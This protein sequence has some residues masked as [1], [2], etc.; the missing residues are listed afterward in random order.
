MSRRFRRPLVAL[1]LLATVLVCGG[2]QA[3]AWY[4]IK[5]GTTST[6]WVSHAFSST[7]RFL[8]GWNDG[9]DEATTSGWR[10][11]GWW[12]IAPGGTSTIQS[13]GFGN[14]YHQ[15]Y[16]HDSVGHVWG[17]G[18]GWFGTPNPAF[19]RCEG[20]FTQSN[21]IPYYTYLPT[22]TSWC[23]GGSCVGDWTSTLVL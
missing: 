14:A 19:S 17:G 3:H 8:C 16:A 23:C 1:A 5:N 4:K 9:C 2:G 18:G 20:L 21:T 12:M 22:R 10:V 11:E 7:Q 6:I 15:I 13:Q